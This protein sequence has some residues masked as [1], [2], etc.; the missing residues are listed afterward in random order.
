[1]EESKQARAEQVIQNHVLVSSAA[2]IVPLPVMDLALV[3]GTQLNMLR[4]LC[5]VY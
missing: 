2:G 4:R 3:S 5:A 1:M